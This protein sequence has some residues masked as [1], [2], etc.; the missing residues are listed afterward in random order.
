MKIFKYKVG[1]EVQCVVKA[2]AINT[3]HGSGWSLGKRFIILKKELRIC[4]RYLLWSTEDEPSYVFDDWVTLVEKGAT[5]QESPKFKVGDKVRRIADGASPG[6]I[7]EVHEIRKIDKEELIYLKGNLTGS[8]SFDYFNSV[9]ELVREK[10]PTKNLII[11]CPTKDLWRRV[12]EKM[13][14]EGGKLLYTGGWTGK[15][16]GMRIEGGRIVDGSSLGFYR[17]NHPNTPITPA[18]EYLGEEGTKT[19]TG[20]QDWQSMDMHIFDM[21]INSCTTSYTNSIKINKPKKPMNKVL[22]AIKDARLTKDE[23]LLRK[24]GMLDEELNLTYE[25]QEAIFEMESIA[26]GYKSDDVRVKKFCSGVDTRV[27]AFEIEDLYN[28]HYAALLEQVTALDK[29]ENL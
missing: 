23:K 5:T 22:K 20:K 12:Q 29:E 7:G 6:M 2:G 11:H 13:F 19:T 26:R 27:S 8:Y 28:K 17:K 21:L 4:G 16:C 25:C 14:G 3:A 15:E 9:Y 10:A 24:H 1:D 18:E